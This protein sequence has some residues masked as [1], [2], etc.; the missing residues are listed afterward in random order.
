M[1]FY[2]IEITNGADSIKGKAVYEHETE[3]EAVATFHQK[4]STAMKSDLYGSTLVMVI[5]RFGTML[6]KEYWQK[7]S[8][9]TEPVEESAN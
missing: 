9:E 5:D 1:K 7:P 4:L 8:E 6:R 3:T 2:V